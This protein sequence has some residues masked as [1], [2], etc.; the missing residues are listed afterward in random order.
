VISID[1][2]ILVRLALLQFEDKKL[3]FSDALITQLNAAYG[4][5]Q[6]ITFDKTT[7]KSG[8]MSATP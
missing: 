6:T 4:C 7:V 8:I 3:D 5:T 2:N 1:T